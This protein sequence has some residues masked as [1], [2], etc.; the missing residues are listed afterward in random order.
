MKKLLISAL[1]LVS[2]VVLAD[3]S[4]WLPAHGATTL[5][6]DLTSGSTD[7]FFIGDESIDLG[8]DLEG[9]FLWFNAKYGYDDIWAFDLRTGYARTSFEGNPTDVEDVADLSVG[10]SY[11]FINEFEADNGWP[12]ITGRA[13]FTI[14]GDYD[15]DR[16]DAIGDGASGVDLSLL[17][18][19]S[20]TPAVALFGDLTLRQRNDDVAD[21][22]KLLLSAYYTTPVPG[23]GLQAALGGIRTDSDVNIGDPGF[24]VD[25]FPL[26]DRD[27]D[28][29]I[30]GANY[31]FGN[32]F[33]VGF[34]YSSV[35]SGK[36]VADSDIGAFTLSYSF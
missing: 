35:L 25:Q 7:R 6:V 24:G 1:C 34:S 33:G 10:V 3:G 30:L 31:G 9:T 14:G 17:V 13:G 22:V 32:G 8:G 20:V 29:L 2:P 27:S 28:W 26:T 23:L 5:S 4:P 16:I 21:G 19:K 36:N 15:T 12:T 18:G 11:Q